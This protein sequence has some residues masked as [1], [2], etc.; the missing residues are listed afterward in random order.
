ML[1]YTR[2]RAARGRSVAGTSAFEYGLLV[3]LIVTVIALAVFALTGL[4]QS[5]T[6]TRC[7]DRSGDASVAGA[8]CSPDPVANLSPPVAPG[9]AATPTSAQQA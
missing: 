6:D 3:V 2:T 9:S 5:A 8:G 4:I 1:E 7:G